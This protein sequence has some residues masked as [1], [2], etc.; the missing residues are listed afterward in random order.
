M[1]IAKTIKNLRRAADRTQQQLADALGVSFQAVSKWERGE[2]YPDITLL[3]RLASLLGVT[4]DVLLGVDEERRQERYERAWVQIRENQRVGR[5]RENV[6][7]YRELYAEYPDDDIIT[8]EFAYRLSVVA[9][10]LPKDEAEPLL[11]E[12]VRLEEKILERSTAEGRRGDARAGLMEH[13][14]KLGEDERVAEF[15]PK[16]NGI[17]R[18][19]YFRFLRGKRRVQE[20]EIEVRNCFEWILDAVACMVDFDDEFGCGFTPEEKLKRLETAIAVADTVIDTGDYKVF[21]EPLAKMSAQCAELSLALGGTENAL[22]HIERAADL[23]RQFDDIIDKVSEVIDLMDQKY[24]VYSQHTTL[25]TISTNGQ[26]RFFGET[27]CG[28]L[29]ESLSRPAFDALRSDTRF[30]AAADALQ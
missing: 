16:Y 1:N 22:A 19:T 15:L 30:T 10:A 5:H 18:E 17:R 28:T 25:F 6:E 12:A 11:R 26:P 2:G 21:A 27:A 9:D 24:P 14:F 7:I 29:R 20:T 4:T 8:H 3:P 13:L 23:A